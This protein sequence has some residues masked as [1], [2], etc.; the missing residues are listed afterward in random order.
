MK[1]ATILAAG[2]IAMSATLARANTITYTLNESNLSA[3]PYTGPYGTVQ[4][5]LTDST[6]ATITF[7]GGSGGGF[8]YIFGAAQMVDVNVNAT[9][10]TV[11]VTSPGTAAYSPGAQNV[12]TFG[13]MNLSIDNS[14][15]NTDATSPVIFT[16]TDTSGTWLSAS[17]VLTADNQGYFAAAHIFVRDAAGANP[18]TGFAG[19]K[20]TTTNRVPDG[21]STIALLGMGLLGLRWVRQI[22]SKKK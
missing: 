19:T 10:F 6:H 17:D 20:T 18:T 4:V 2:L 14:D 22:A 7:T 15:G 11:S 3:P 9:T 12:S 8:T 1:I 13:S 21:G 16:V 5:N